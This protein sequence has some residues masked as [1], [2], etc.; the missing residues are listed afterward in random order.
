MERRLR[1]DRE[2]GSVLLSGDA[3]RLEV[4]DLLVTEPEELPE[5]VVVCLAQ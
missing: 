2:P 4:G 1:E 5:D 3:P